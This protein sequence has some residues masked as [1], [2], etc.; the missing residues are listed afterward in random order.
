MNNKPETPRE[1]LDLIVS[2]V[3]DSREALQNTSIPYI[4][5]GGFCTV[6]TAASYALAY[7]GLQNLILPFW[8][9][10]YFLVA[11][12]NIVYNR[13]KQSPGV[14]YFSTKLSIILWT[15]MMGFGSALLI[16]SFLVKKPISL[17]LG[18]AFLSILIAIGYLVN[19]V[20]TSYRSILILGILWGIG[21]ILCMIVPNLLAPA[22]VGTMAFLFEFIPGLILY[23][24][25]EGNKE[26]NV[27]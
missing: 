26:E 13:R 23:S 5:W 3:N 6:G 27:K 24:R 14:R 4:I 7:F 2:I 20:L 16:V 8:A 15:G 18:M 11:L 1:Q 9:G 21:G 10:I 12:V 17:Q 25:N 19:S 22:L